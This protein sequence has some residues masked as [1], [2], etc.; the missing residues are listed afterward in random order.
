MAGEKFVKVN[1]ANGEHEET[2]A[3]QTGGSG[4]E[5]KIPSLDA[6]GR[7]DETMMPLGF[8][9]D[10][11]S[12]ICS[13]DINAGDQVNTFWDAG[14]SAMRV[15]KADATTRGME[16]TGFVKES[17]LDGEAI[18][19]FHEGTNDALTGLTPG[20]KVFLSTTAGGII[21]D[22]TTLAAG[23]VL[24]CV[25]YTISDTQITFEPGGITV[26]A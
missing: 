1:R 14:A 9:D 22:P 25:G 2:I 16:A 7:L 8:G 6:A 24:Q 10:A 12:F 4:N 3:T 21:Y 19:V 20:K 18:K 5:N 11:N 23:N 26:L 13:G 17:K 15:R